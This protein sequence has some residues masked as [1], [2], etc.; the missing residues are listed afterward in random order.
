MHL[1]DESPMFHL[2][3]ASPMDEGPV[4]VLFHRLGPYHLARLRAACAEMPVVVI[5]GCTLD[6]TYAWAKVEPDPRFA[7]TTL[8]NDG[9]IEDKPASVVLRRV[10]EA[11]SAIRPS[12]VAIPGWSGKFAIAALQCCV[13]QG[14]PSVVMSETTP[15]DHPRV[16]WKEWIKRRIVGCFLSGLVGGTPHANY[17]VSLGMDRGHIFQGYDAVDNAF[18]ETNTRN[19]RHSGTRLEGVPRD[20]FLSSCRF[21]ETKNLQRLLQAYA[22]YR[23]RCELATE[24][25]EQAQPWD[26]V[27]LGDGPLRSR[28]EEQRAELNLGD[29]VH[30]PGFKQYNQLPAFYAA[31]KVFVH[32]STTEPWGLVVNEAM[33]SSLPVLVSNRSGC[34]ADLVQNGVNGFTFDPEDTSTLANL[35]SRMSLGSFDL[36]AMGRQSSNLIQ[37][38]GTSSFSSGLRSAVRVAHGQAKRVRCASAVQGLLAALLYWQTPGPSSDV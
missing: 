35:L 3:P 7:V 13:R 8:F 23:R 2:P 22:E 20:F 31:A 18:F 16:G 33:A 11:L 34:A 1:R 21:V 29:V 17:L 5:Q 6:R 9:D 19:I 25:R 30:F 12:A 10:A 4:A 26:L 27:V 32:P 24:R 36:E 37:R 28:L 38:W 15:W 14:L